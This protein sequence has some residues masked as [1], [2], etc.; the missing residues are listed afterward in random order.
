MAEPDLPIHEPK[1][2]D[3]QNWLRLRDLAE[4]AV[5]RGH[6]YQDTERRRNCLYYLNPDEDLSYCWHPQVRILV[7]ADWW[8]H[9]CEAIAAR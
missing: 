9:W 3:E 2:I 5:L 8:C 4:R 1:P 6:P 7:G